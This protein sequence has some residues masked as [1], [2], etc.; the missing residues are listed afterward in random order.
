MDESEDSTIDL[1]PHEYLL[2][3]ENKRKKTR[4]LQKNVAAL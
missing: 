2:F 1:K 3:A 4:Q